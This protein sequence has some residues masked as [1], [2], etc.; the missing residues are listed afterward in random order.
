[1]NDDSW[2]A[3]FG[4]L[5]LAGIE[6]GDLHRGVTAFF[7][8]RK[9]GADS[10]GL[11]D[12]TLDRLAKRLSRGK[13]VQNFPSYSKRIAVNVYREYCRDQENFRAALRELRYLTLDVEGPKKMLMFVASARRHAS[14]HCPQAISS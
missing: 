13:S 4:A 14:R 7:I 10:E 2:Q 12:M 3:L 8:G 1:L 6:Y 5:K 11:A 9:C